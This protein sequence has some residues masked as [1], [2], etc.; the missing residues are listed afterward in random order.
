MDTGERIFEL[1]DMMEMSAKE[2]SHATGISQGNIT[3]WKK[4]RSKPSYGALVKISNSLNVSED[5]L[6]NG[7]GEVFD[8]KT[9][10]EKE[11]NESRLSPLGHLSVS[12]IEVIQD[13]RSLGIHGQTAVYN[14]IKKEKALQTQSATERTPAL[15]QETQETA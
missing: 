10:D 11:I 1:L 6:V 14:A 5:W 9:D 4:K 12:E 15:A 13:L 2:L 3:D 7:K 8:M